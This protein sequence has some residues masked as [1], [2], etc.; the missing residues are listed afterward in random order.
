MLTLLD[1]EA[2]VQGRA[3]LEATIGR[4]RTGEFPVAPA[5]RRDWDLCEGCPALGWL[6]S[7]P[8]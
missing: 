4:I 3:E 8:L 7:G 5:E 6:C 2:M 1:G